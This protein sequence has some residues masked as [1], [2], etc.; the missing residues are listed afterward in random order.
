MLVWARGEAGDWVVTSLT[1]WKSPENKQTT[2][3]NLPVNI[4]EGE[5]RRVWSVQPTRRF[6]RPF[7]PPLFEERPR[8]PCPCTR[9]HAEVGK[10]RGHAHEYVSMAPMPPITRVHSVIGFYECLRASVP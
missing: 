5:K 6:C 7:H 4:P 8:V 2:R 9:G 10:V 1:L 3:K